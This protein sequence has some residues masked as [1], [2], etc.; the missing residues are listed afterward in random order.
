MTVYVD[1]IW[2]L[3]LLFDTLLLFLSAL[4]L[5]RK[6]NYWRLLAGGFVG[7]IIILL[8]LTPIHA[9]SNHPVIK[10]FFSVGMIVTVFGYKNFRYFLK[11]LMTL[12]LTT[13][14][15][16]GGL[17]GAHYFIQFNFDLSANLMLAS[18]KGFGDPISWL[19]VII[20]FPLAWH[21]SKISIEN[22]EMTKINY[23][24]LINVA[25]KIGATELKVK[26]LIDSGNQLHDPLS[27]M[28]VM[29]VSLYNYPEELPEEIMNLTGD[30]DT[31]IFAD[32]TVSSEWGHKLRLIPYKVVGREHELIIA[33]K[34][35]EIMLEMEQ[36]WGIVEK[37]LISFTM[38][39]L[40]VDHSFQCIIHPKMLVGVKTRK[41]S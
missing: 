12:Y 40:S 9:Y 11:G 3:N 41:V 21:F 29:F 31:L 32:N 6:I 35:D 23:E 27:G 38:Q 25:V 7:S 24:Q 5:K 33:I 20:G 15:I 19:F 17:I 10:L 34:P 8:S 16:G 13:F 36:G 26:G 14:L 1:V 22:I 4:I 39:Q 2:A 28:P 37:G 18:V 30:A